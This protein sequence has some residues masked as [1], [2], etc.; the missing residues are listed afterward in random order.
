M[1]SSASCRDAHAVMPR[2]RGI[3]DRTASDA[4]VLARISHRTNARLGGQSDRC[5][6]CV[7]SMLAGGAG[8]REECWNHFVLPAQRRSGLGGPWDDAARTTRCGGACQAGEPRALA[9]AARRRAACPQTSAAGQA[10]AIPT[11]IRRTLNCTKAPILSNL[12][13][14]EPQ[15]ALAKCV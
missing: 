3:Q 15:V 5:V 11:L 9:A 12:R 4:V 8:R 2:P 13:R 10:D 1:P 6:S 14:M 7:V